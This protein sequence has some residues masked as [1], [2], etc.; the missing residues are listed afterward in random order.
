MSA[1]GSGGEPLLVV[2][3]LEKR[4]APSGR[5][6]GRE[7]L[8]LS[9][10]DFELARGE[11]LALV[12]ESGS[13]KSTLAR[14]ATG[15]LPAS[16]GS[17]RFDGEELIGGPAR[18]LAPLR[19]RIGF[20]FQDPRGSF[21]PRQR[22]DSLLCEPL[23][24]HG[25]LRP[26][27]R[28]LR[29]L[30]LLDAVGLSAEHLFRYPQEF[31]GGQR[32]RLAI[33]RALA[34]EPELLVLDEPTSALDVSVQA[35][36]LNLLS[37]LRSEFGLSLLLIAHDLAVVQH[38]ADR[39]AVLYLGRLVELAPAAALFRAPAHPY[40]QALLASR[41]RIEA[42]S[43]AAPARLSGDPPSPLSPPS[44]CA[45]H[46]RCPRRAAAPDPR[47]ER[48]SPALRGLGPQVQVACHVVSA[49]GPPRP[50]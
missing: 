30:A 36:I 41:P 45:F 15:L 6:G 5:Q 28:R 26:K 46:P 25:H 44:G 11:C 40:T 3:G 39:V 24:I 14:C 38:L 42:G 4:F 33:A 23:A 31:S 17:A 9:G 29:A 43:G 13:G 35:Q 2:R 12:G 19:R 50:D 27:D 18:E 22:V 47:C 34:L 37:A 16:A 7:L 49:E 10:I 1:P 32:Q 8:A 20:V 21:D 48:E